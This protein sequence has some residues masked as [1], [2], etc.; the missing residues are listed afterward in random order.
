MWLIDMVLFRMYW[1]WGAATSTE[2]K[3][4]HVHVDEQKGLG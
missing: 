2:L 4:A 1:V 3:D